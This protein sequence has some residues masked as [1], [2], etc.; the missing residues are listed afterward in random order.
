MSKSARTLYPAIYRNMV[1]VISEAVGLGGRRRRQRRVQGR[2]AGGGRE[3]RARGRADGDDGRQRRGLG[4]LPRL[5]RE[6]RR[7]GRLARPLPNRVENPPVEERH[8]DA[9]DV[10]G[11]HRRVVTVRPPCRRQ[12]RLR[13]TRNH[14]IEATTSQDPPPK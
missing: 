1:W 7:G 2:P 14:T 13:S 5:V 9:R 3:R 8:D 6:G 11:A 12:L 10:E 4:R